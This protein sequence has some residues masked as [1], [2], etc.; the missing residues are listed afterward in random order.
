MR[1]CS[2]LGYAYTHGEG[3]EKDLARAVTLYQK[4][5]DGGNVVG[6]HNGAFAL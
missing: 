4:S 5:C 1:A 2:T 3:V 6:C